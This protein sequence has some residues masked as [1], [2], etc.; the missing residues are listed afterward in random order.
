M[1][2]GEVTLDDSTTKIG[3]YRA[4]NIAAFYLLDTDRTYGTV[5]TALGDKTTTE[6]A[7]LYFSWQRKTGDFSF[8]AN[9]IC[10]V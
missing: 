3:I 5:A 4:D 9:P 1:T 8:S 2:S 10:W 6:T 7:D